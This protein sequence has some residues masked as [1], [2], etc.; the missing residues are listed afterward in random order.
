MVQTHN[1]DWVRFEDYKA[2]EA[3]ALAA[4]EKLEAAEELIED[5]EGIV[6]AYGCDCAADVRQLV[7]AYRAPGEGDE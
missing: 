7:A 2:L 1:G 5:L 3:Y 4:R 6:D